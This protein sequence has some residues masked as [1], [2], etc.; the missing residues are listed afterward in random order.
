MVLGEEVAQHVILL[1]LFLH[2][3]DLV[4]QQ[5]PQSTQRNETEKARYQA[6]PALDSMD[7]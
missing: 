1:Q 4:P 6:L 5:I 2:D 7:I 3:R